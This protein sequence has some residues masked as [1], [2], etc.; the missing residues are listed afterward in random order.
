M[1]SKKRTI[2]VQKL[3]APPVS[4]DI[5]LPMTGPQGKHYLV[6]SRFYSDY[7][8]E[9]YQDADEVSQAM[10][11]R[12]ATPSLTET[13]FEEAAGGATAGLT[14]AAAKAM[15]YYEG[16][17]PE[18]EKMAQFL[19]ERRTK[20][21]EAHPKAAKI[22]RTAGA[23]LPAAKAMGAAR[24]AGVL[25]A[26]AAGG[27]TGSGAAYLA[28]ATED[29][30]LP[31]LGEEMLK[32]GA[33]GALTAGLLK[34]AGGL[35]AKGKEFASKPLAG[36]ATGGDLMRAAPKAAA[37]MA[38]GGPAG[39]A[40]AVAGLAAKA[41]PELGKTLSAVGVKQA[42]GLVDKMVDPALNTVGRGLASMAT[43]GAKAAPALGTAAGTGLSSQQKEYNIVGP[44]GD[45]WTIDVEDLQDA[46]DQGYQIDND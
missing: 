38:M 41:S 34:G 44:Q 3:R 17:L 6:P 13:I 45:K 31:E 24:G 28:E 11:E 4:E 46:L 5:M 16:G 40:P 29:A 9:G 20:R 32:G 35:A 26:G 8:A 15:A 36:A 42:S 27:A 23:I 7:R 10:K 21:R 14:E 33:A 37:G 25:A 22:A 1:A 18:M 2:K 39:A 12:M 19:K 43:A 30:R